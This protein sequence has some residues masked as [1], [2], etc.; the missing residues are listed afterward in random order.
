M[1]PKPNPNQPH[2]LLSSS[3]ATSFLGRSP[4]R[5][6]VSPLASQS[7]P[8]PSTPKQTKN[9]PHFPFFFPNSQN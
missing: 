4:P 1:L 9:Q 5:A 8:F 7:F 2:F 6:V 3:P